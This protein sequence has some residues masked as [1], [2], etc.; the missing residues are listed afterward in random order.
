MALLE[1]KQVARGIGKVSL[2]AELGRTQLP[3]HF[4]TATLTTL[5]G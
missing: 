4:S 3:C 1:S 2:P 5:W